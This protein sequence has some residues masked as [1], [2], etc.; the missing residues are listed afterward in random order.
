MR[1][2]GQHPPHLTPF[3]FNS[4]NHHAIVAGRLMAHPSDY[5]GFGPLFDWNAF[6]PSHGSTSNRRGVIGD[7]TSKP[8]AQFSVGRMEVE[9]GHDCP[10]EIL[11]VLGL[12][13]LSPLGIRRSA[14]GVG[15]SGSLGFQFGPD[16]VD[17]LCRCPYTS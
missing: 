11:D 16:T 1:S 14:F 4:W 2:P 13:V 3:P 6:R 15:L 10:K 17:G 9:E 7:G 12:D 5:S 8:L